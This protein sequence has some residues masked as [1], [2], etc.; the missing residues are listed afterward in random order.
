MSPG[1]CRTPGRIVRSPLSPHHPQPSFCQ[2][3]APTHII[4]EPIFSPTSSYFPR[5][6]SGI[7]LPV[8][9]N[10]N[11]TTQPAKPSTLVT[12]TDVSLLFLTR[13]QSATQPSVPPS[14]GHSSPS[15]ITCCLCSGL[16]FP[17][18]L[19]PYCQSEFTPFGSHWIKICDSFLRG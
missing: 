6:S 9:G 8:T 11:F 5:P 15:T 18:P 17:P 2:P 1:P 14:F 13:S 3:G 12:L 16:L 10:T 4:P 7:L 19:P